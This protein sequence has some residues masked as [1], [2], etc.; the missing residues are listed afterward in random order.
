MRDVI[1]MEIADG[2]AQLAKL[3]AARQLFG[4]QFAP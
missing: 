1:G 4:R 3:V 2:T